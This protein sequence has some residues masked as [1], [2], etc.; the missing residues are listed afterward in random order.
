MTVNNRR[1]GEKRKLNAKFVFAGAG[2]DTL[3]LLQKSG[4]KEIRGFAGFPIGGKFL[5]TDNPGLT[6]AHRAKVYGAPR[7]A[8]RRSGRCTWTC[9]RQRQV[10]AGVRSVRRLVAEV[11]ETRPLQRSA[12]VGAAEQRGVDARRRNHQDHAAQVSDRPATAHRTRS[13]TRLARIRAQCS[14]FRLGADGGR[15]AGAGYPWDRRKGGVLEFD[16]TLVGTADGS[17]VGLLGGSPGA[18]TAV[19]IM[20]D[21][22]SAALPTGISRG[23]PRSRR[24]CPRWGLSFPANGRCSTRIWSWG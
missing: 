7:R 4:I 9:G 11:L 19:P 8:R 23:C 3:P 18:S 1:T 15:S 20:L 6:A 13:R 16:T 24:W 12:A 5:R 21:S 2:G 22:Y 14:G 10:M 17:I